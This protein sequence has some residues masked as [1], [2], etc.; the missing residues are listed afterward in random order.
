MSENEIGVLLSERYLHEDITVRWE[1][2][3]MSVLFPIDSLS[4]KTRVVLEIG[5]SKTSSDC[6]PEP[7]PLA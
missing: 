4:V 5:T 7:Q 3:Q 6:T 1:A 2:G